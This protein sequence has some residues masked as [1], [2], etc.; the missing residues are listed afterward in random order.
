MGIKEIIIIIIM[1][2][3]ILEELINPIEPYIALY[4]PYRTLFTIAPTSVQS[5]SNKLFYW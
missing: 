4:K 5:N 1:K 3:R 2:Q